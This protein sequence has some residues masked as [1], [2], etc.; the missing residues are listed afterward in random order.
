MVPY[1]YKICVSNVCKYVYNYY[2]YKI[3][4]G[5]FELVPIM[6]RGLIFRRPVNNIPGIVAG[7]P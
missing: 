2:V 5:G 4:K 6:P 7:D 1:V 3:L